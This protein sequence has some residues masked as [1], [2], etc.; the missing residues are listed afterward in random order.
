MKQYEM[1]LVAISEKRV[2]ISAESAEAAAQMVEKIYSETDILDFSNRDVTDVSV[3]AKAA[4][5]KES[6]CNAYPE[7]CGSCPY[8]CPLDGKCMRDDPENRC[9]ECVNHCK[10]CGRCEAKESG[11]CGQECIECGHCCP[12]CACC[13]HPVKEQQ[14]GKHLFSAGKDTK[15]EGGTQTEG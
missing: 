8:S 13:T 5:I 15:T 11:D 1:T 6:V 14:P 2:K 3:L 7:G 4:D 9:L 12:E 10:V